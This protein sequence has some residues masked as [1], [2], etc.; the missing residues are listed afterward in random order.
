MLIKITD[1]GPSYKL[2]F[3]SGVGAMPTGLYDFIIKITKG[4]KRVD[5]CDY[6]LS[7]PSGNPIIFYEHG[8]MYIWDYRMVAPDVQQECREFLR[9]C[10]AA[11]QK[12]ES[13]GENDALLLQRFNL[14]TWTPGD[15]TPALP[16]VFINHEQQD[17]KVVRRI[18]YFLNISF[19]DPLNQVNLWADLSA[20]QNP[21]KSQNDG[22]GGD[23]G[24]Y[25]DFT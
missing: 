19:K 11:L 4:A 25:H 21:I 2:E 22:S 5:Q 1:N 14:Q 9:E 6:T 12:T 18:R 7:G 23:T 3:N 8:N 20:P 10:L 13:G 24:T 17:N 16:Q 15:N